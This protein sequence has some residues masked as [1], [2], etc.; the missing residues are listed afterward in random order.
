[1][2]LVSLVDDADGVSSD[3]EIDQRVD[4]FPVGCCHTNE[5]RLLA[6]CGDRS[7]G[8]SRSGDVSDLTGDAAQSLLGMDR[9]GN[10]NA[11]YEENP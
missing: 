6:R 7:S 8:N 2:R 3:G 9:E 11:G 5:A 1:M 10:S 4:A